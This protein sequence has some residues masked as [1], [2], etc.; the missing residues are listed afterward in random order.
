MAEIIY[1]DLD[2]LV[3]RLTGGIPEAA[4]DKVTAEVK[5]ILLKHIK[6]DI[7][8]AYTPKEGAWINNTTYPRRFSLEKNDI[9]SYKEPD[10]T[11]VVTSD[12]VPNQS[13]V[14]GYH[15]VSGDHGA[16]LQLLESGNMGIWKSGFARP[17]VSNAQREV[18]SSDAIRAIAEKGLKGEIG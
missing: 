14:K 10:G 1:D 3:D 6:S 4:M 8:G 2:E 15:F 7:Y 18:D 12:A 11:I 5:K 13:V 16:F 9:I 17:A